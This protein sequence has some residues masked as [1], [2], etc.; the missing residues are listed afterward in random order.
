MVI[1]YFDTILFVA[2]IG[3]PTDLAE[4]GETPGIDTAEDTGLV[5]GNVSAHFAQEELRMQMASLVPPVEICMAGSKRAIKITTKLCD[6][7]YDNVGEMIPKS[8]IVDAYQNKDGTAISTDD[9]D[10]M[11]EM[12]TAVFVRTYT[13]PETPLIR[14][15][16]NFPVPQGLS[17]EEQLNTTIT[18]KLIYVNEHG[19]EEHTDDVE[20][21]YNQGPYE[22][23]FPLSKEEG[24]GEDGWL[25]QDENDKPFLKLRFR[26]K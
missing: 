1:H 20:F 18:F 16:I 13:V 19:V 12:G 22:V 2:K 17:Q 21:K 25:F 23:K 5:K 26:V 6:S 8:D 14:T 3:S 11:L 4:S 15:F 24:E 7:K 10:H 9:V